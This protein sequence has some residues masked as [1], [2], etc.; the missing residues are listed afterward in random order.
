M[1]TPN[2]D[3]KEDI[4]LFK[5]IH[6]FYKNSKEIENNDNILI[7]FL[8]DHNIIKN[9]SD[10]LSLF[11]KELLKQ[12]QKGNNII[13]PFLDPCYDLI[14]AYINSNNANDKNIFN[15]IFIQLIENSF[16]NRKNL[17]PIYAY[18]TEIYSDV[19]T[20]TE[21]DE[22]FNNFSKMI[23][24][25]KLFYFYS[26]NKNINKKLSSFC[27]LGS[28]LVLD[29]K[30]RLSINN[31]MKIKINFL[32]NNFLK[33][34]NQNDDLINTNNNKIKYSTLSKYQNE[35]I[36]SIDIIFKEIRDYI[37]IEININCK[38]VLENHFLKKYKFNILNNFYGQIK[39]IEISF[40]NYNNNKKIYSKFISPFPLKDNGIIF[41]SNFDIEENIEKSLYQLQSGPNDFNYDI[42]NPQKVNISKQIN[43][44]LE[45]RAQDKNLIKVNYINYKEEEFDIIDYFGG[46]TQFLPFINIINGLYKNKNISEINNIKKKEFL[47]EFTKN[48]L[49]IIF[50]NITN[51]GKKKQCYLSKYWTFYL[52]ILNK[53]EILKENNLNIDTNEF[54]SKLYEADYNIYFLIFQVF[55]DYVNSKN[56]QQYDILNNLISKQKEKEK[57]HNNQNIFG[58][59]NNQI[60]RNIMK[61]LFLYNRLWSKQYLFFEN[62]Y[63]C[64]KYR[65]KLKIKYKRINYFT[66]NFQQPL[67]YPLL[68]INKYYPKFKKFSID[69]LYKNPK[70]KILNYDFSLDNFCDILDETLV[71]G[72]LNNNNDNNLQK[73]EC[74]LIKKMY[75]IKGEIGICYLSPSVPT[76]Y[77]ISKNSENDKKCNKNNTNTNKSEYN[78]H[79]CYGSVFSSL[80]KEDNK[81]IFISRNDIMFILLRIYYYRPSGLEIFTFDNK[82]YLFNFWKPL[83]LNDEKN[84]I[85]K[86]FQKDFEPIYT[87]DSKIL[88][89][90]NPIYLDIL[91]PLFNDDIYKWNE[92]KYY[93]SNF[94]K[95]MIINLFSNRTFN[96]LNQYPV[97]P[98]LYN[99]I[100]KE[101]QMDQPIG[102]QELTDESKSRK[103]LIIDSYNYET[104]DEEDSNYEKSYFNLFYSNITYTCNFLIR[105]FPYSFIGIEY[106]GDGFDDPNR[107]FF[108]IN[109][110]FVN[111]LNQRSDLRELIPEMFYFSPLFYNKNELELKKLSNGKE[112]DKVIIRDYNENNIKKYIFL[113]NMR[114]HLEKEKNLNLWIDLIFGVNKD[115]NENHERY[116]NKNSNISFNPNTKIFDDD[117]IMQS[118]DFGVLPFQLL[119]DKFPEKIKISEKLE[120]E[121]YL[122]NKKQF[123]LDHIICLNDGK[124][125]F[126][127]KG[128]KGIN[129]DYSKIIN[130]IKAENIPFF[131]IQNF[132]M[133]ENLNENNIF[134]LFVGDVFGNL[135]VY[136]KI[137][138]TTLLNIRN[139]IVKDNSIDKTLIDEIDNGHYHLLKC[140]NDHT[141]EIKFIDYNPRLN[142][143][144]DYALDGFINLYTMPTLKLIRSFQIKDYVK[145]YDINYKIQYVVLISN[146]FPMICFIDIEK[147]VYIL[148]INGELINEKEIDKDAYILFSIDKNCGLFNDHISYI[149]KDEE[150][151]MSLIPQY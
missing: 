10:K 142:L 71:K 3:L 61:Q 43:I 34:I 19:D 76:I 119:K 85:T 132:F 75:H 56:K 80:Q 64:F 31:Y 108:S 63:D 36:S 100:K 21:S 107:L 111:T 92:K 26:E 133:K 125:S 24:L 58:K 11:I 140:L 23:N 144:I 131:F 38:K 47:I 95:L 88:G 7:K 65:A 147:K 9:N 27:F 146:P 96:D 55:L 130:K 141:N 151:Q 143:V 106:Q 25:W 127:C 5:C 90:Y 117:I 112:I 89:W 109:S 41:A 115:Y 148:D 73:S 14:E 4:E 113:K 104:I 46:I 78:S 59:T 44:K 121:I 83:N 105:V 79:L 30:E 118:Y 49:L 35:D 123:E 69:N 52:Y 134:Y 74:C 82:S 91:R 126:I 86:L 136:T 1:S 16:I 149:I 39:S 93:Y 138:K 62:V 67:I 101:R 12:I 2:P 94:D 137:K 135:Y 84:Q 22:I 70:D 33:Y 57:N 51:S 77:F 87:P 68:E 99:E 20:L 15:D 116:Y 124:R 97:F 60:Y 81:L 53:I 110:T 150:N 129:N 120:K 128:E 102:F 29:I 139:D 32:N 17:I 54:S 48:I 42:Y 13:L 40:N 66:T 37:I 103:Q 145:N 114:E 122:L 28:G 6:N 50:K 98:M 8:K 72:Y 45:L 18:F